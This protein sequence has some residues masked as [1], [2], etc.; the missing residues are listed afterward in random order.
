MATE[1]YD[2]VV[3]AK[4]RVNEPHNSAEIIA[5]RGYTPILTPYQVNWHPFHSVVHYSTASIWLAFD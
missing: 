2:I 1:E 3:E 5:K 4:K